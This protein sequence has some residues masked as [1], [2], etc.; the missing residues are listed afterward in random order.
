MRLSDTQLSPRYRL[1]LGAVAVLGIVT[2]ISLA[3][4]AFIEAC[5]TRTIEKFESNVQSDEKNVNASRQKVEEAKQESS[6]VNGELK[7]RREERENATVEVNQK[8]VERRKATANRERVRR[9]RI[10]NVNSADLKRILDE[11]ERN[12]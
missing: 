7:V 11:A 2:V 6:A 5:E 8:I 1:L 9:S 12:R 10:A 4:G 3:V